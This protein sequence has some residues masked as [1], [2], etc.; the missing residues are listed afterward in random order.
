[1]TRSR[2]ELREAVDS[3]VR[4]A[5]L[6]SVAGEI[7]VSHQTVADLIDAPDKSSEK[8]IAKVDAWLDRRA[9]P[10]ENATLLARELERLHARRDLIGQVF[11]HAVAELAAA[12][13]AEAMRL[14]ADAARERARAARADGD[15]AL[16]RAQ[17]GRDLPKLDPTRPAAPATD[18]PQQARHGG[19]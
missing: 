11:T 5:D 9:A 17:V 19:R 3:A 14:D 7:G 4:D 12:I 1:M 2:D 8:T 13:R 16:A 18:Q 15:G 6:R 10:A